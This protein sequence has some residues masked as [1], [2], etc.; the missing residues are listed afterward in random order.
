MTEQKQI[1]LETYIEEILKGADA[2]GAA[3]GVVNADGKVLYQKFFGW[4]DAERELPID[5]NTLFGIASVTKSFT[6]LAVMQLQE[7]GVL[8]LEDPIAKYVPEYQDPE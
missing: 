7:A 5:E 6:A 3:L 1:E 8:S 2:R 4:R